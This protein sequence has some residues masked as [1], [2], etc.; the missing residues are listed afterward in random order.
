VTWDYLPIGYWSAVETHVGVMV[1]CLPAIRSLERSL[2]GPK[3]AT[4]TSY[5]GNNTKG[6]SKK[7]SS[8]IAPSLMWSSKSGITRLN[9]LGRSEVDKDDF[10]RL[11]EYEM[12]G[13]AGTEK[14]TND[15]KVTA[16]CSSETPLSRSFRSN[17]DDLP[18]ATTAAPMGRP[19]GGIMVRTEYSVDGFRHSASERERGRGRVR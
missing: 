19:L 4:N 15:D 13:G 14:F 1:A 9:T 5:Y 11:N 12:R 10:V 17:E 7:S 8:K 6:S 2:R 18:L 3:P 16:Q